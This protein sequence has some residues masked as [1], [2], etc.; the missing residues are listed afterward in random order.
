M[1]CSD[2]S[3]INIR[4]TW[5]DNRYSYKCHIPEY[6]G[7]AAGSTRRP[8]PSTAA[9]ET[10]GALAPPWL[11]RILSVNIDFSCLTYSDWKISF[12]C[13]PHLNHSSATG[14][15]AKMGVVPKIARADTRLFFFITTN[16]LIFLNLPLLT[17]NQSHAL[18]NWSHVLQNRCL[19]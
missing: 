3:D 14:I 2:S 7:K 9:R 19:N 17:L 13:K 18:I 10:K 11:W 5:Y 8:P 12:T 15:D 1:T 4:V 16:L 6:H